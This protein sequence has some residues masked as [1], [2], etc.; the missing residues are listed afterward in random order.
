MDL[1]RLI[2]IT[3]KCSGVFYLCVMDCT[4]KETSLVIFGS[5]HLLHSFNVQTIFLN[6][7]LSVCQLAYLL[8]VNTRGNRYFASSPLP[9]QF[10]S[11]HEVR[12]TVFSTLELVHV[13]R[14]K[15]VELATMEIQ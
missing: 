9:N 5:R 3:F 2:P 13:Y 6:L 14:Q 8:Y 10:L 7:L 12:S 11:Q 1:V 15:L 4:L